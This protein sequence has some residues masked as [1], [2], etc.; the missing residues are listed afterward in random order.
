MGNLNDNVLNQ[1]SS[2]IGNQEQSFPT[3]PRQKSN[4][5]L[6]IIIGVLVV[7]LIAGIGI[8]GFYVYESKTTIENEE[9]T[10]TENPSTT[11]EPTTSNQDEQTSINYSI[12]VK[13]NPTNKT[14]TDIY[15]EDPKTGQETFYITLSDVY[16]NHYHNAE[17]H[18]GN[19]YIIHRTGGDSGYETNPNWTDELWKYNQ[20]K[21]GQKLYSVRG[22]DFRVSDDEKLI[23]IITNEE[24]V[25]LN[26]DGSKIKTFQQ[27]VVNP[28]NS[29]MFGFL[30]WGPDAIWLD[31]SCG[32]NIEG[33]VKINTLNYAVTNYDLSEL[34][35]GA[36]FAINVYEEKIA[37]SNFPIMFDV[38]SAEEYERS[39]AKVNLVVY[40]LNSKSQQTIATSVT[41]K[42]EPKWLDENTLEY[43]NPNGEGRLTKQ[44]P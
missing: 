17:Y 4:R 16:R 26:N 1:Q 20:Q 14:K 36:E 23:A 37:F 25:L 42:F 29:P 27:V 40:D 9:I 21:Q 10:I 31:N 28:K 7:F 12:V 34:P 3:I 6:K 33:L 39:G 22:L 8:S 2:R 18:N 24:F 35:A 15:L 11:P 5:N 44:I 43:N 38:V 19:L 32:P 30:A 13:E 41:K